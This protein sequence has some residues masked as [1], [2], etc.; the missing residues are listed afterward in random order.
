MHDLARPLA[1]ARLSPLAATLLLGAVALSLVV[2]TAL[3]TDL[4]LGLG[5][6]VALL[7]APLVV[8]DLALAVGAWAA[9]VSIQGV[10]A[11]NLAE[12]A[13]A[14]L[15]ALVWIVGVIAG[16]PAVRTAW[17]SVRAA[18]ALAAALVAW[19]VLSLAWSERPDLVVADL[20]QWAVAASVF[21][22]VAT[23]A[24]GPRNLRVV[25]TGFLLGTLVTVGIGLGQGELDAAAGTHLER[26]ADP[27]VRLEGADRDPNF[28]A[29]GVVPAIAFAAALLPG[30]RT[31][32][33]IGLLA[34]VAFLGLG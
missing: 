8:A 26:A 22:I 4:S 30:A 10:P 17:P 21:P 34:A 12:N 18:V 32:R 27:A 16:V 20:R 5:L 14:A 31:M 11:L 15:I 2:G 1:V 29:A 9:L 28:L 33:R 24:S 3:A 6:L 23:A 13:L 7:A 19:T 25:L